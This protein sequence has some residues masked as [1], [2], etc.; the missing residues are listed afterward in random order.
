MKK[1]IKQIPGIIY[2]AEN[3]ENKKIYIGATTSDL[4][5]RKMDHIQKANVGAGHQ[6]QNAI[7]TCGAQ[8]FD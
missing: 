6:F 8:S 2:L 3:K 4:E 5:T 1:N 7:S